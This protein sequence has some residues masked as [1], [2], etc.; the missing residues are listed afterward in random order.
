MQLSIVITTKNRKQYLLDCIHSIFKSKKINFQYE[1]III[2]DSSSDGTENIREQV[3]QHKYKFK[4]IFFYHQQKSLK[5]VKARNVG[6]RLA[7][8]RYVLFVDDDNIIHPDMISNLVSF[9]NTTPTYGIVGPSMYN[10]FNKKKYMD[11][12]K[13]N[14]FLAKTTGVVSNDS[15]GHY[16]SDG[17]PNVFL[18]KKDVFEK[19]GY[20]DEQLIQTFTEPDFSLNAKKNGYK[21]VTY[22]KAITYHNSDAS[23]VLSRTIGSVPAKA[24]CLIRNRFIIVKRYGS[25]LNKLIFLVF[26]SWGWPL[27]YSMLAISIGKFDLIRLYWAGFYDGLNYFIF[28][29]FRVSTKL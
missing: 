24:Y 9:A 16:C 19:C 15:I 8:G 13:I 10:F 28:N 26:F 14:L 17:I 7:R 4:N 29:K 2:D 3:L 1:I 12:Q 21:T 22:N 23:R 25:F 11:Y 27:I 5:M 20:F 18:V 6:A